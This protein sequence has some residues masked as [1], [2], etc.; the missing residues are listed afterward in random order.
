MGGDTRLNADI[1]NFTERFLLLIRLG[2]QIIKTLSKHNRALSRVI[3]WY[4]CVCVCVCIEKNYRSFLAHHPWHIIYIVIDKL[5]IIIPEPDYEQNI[6]KK[7]LEVLFFSRS[8]L[9]CIYNFGL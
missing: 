1:L 3:S 7:W 8:L 4:L 6:Q 9:V 5:K 2:D